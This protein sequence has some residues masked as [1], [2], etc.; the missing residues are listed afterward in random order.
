M[1]TRENA[2]QLRDSLAP[3]RFGLSNP[4]MAA[5]DSPLLQQYKAHYGLS[6][7][8]FDTP[9]HHVFGTIE[10]RS[11]QLVC[12]Y[13]SVPGTEQKGTA[14]LLHGYFDH[15]GIYG[16]L[17]R[18]CLQQGL[19]VVILDLP[20]HGLSSGTVGSI[21]SFAQYTKALVD[22]LCL[23]ESQLVNKPWSLIGQSTGGAVIID[24]LLSSDL[25][26][27]YTF[28]HVVVL[29]P[30]LR[31]RHW[32]RNKLLFLLT[33]RFT[34]STSR[35][36]SVNSHDKEFLQFLQHHDQLQSRYLSADWIDAMIHYQNRFRKAPQSNQLLHIIQ[37]SGDGTVDWQY[38]LPKLQQKF[39]AAKTYMIAGARHH[40]VNELPE[41]RNKV[42]SVLDEILKSNQSEM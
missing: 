25:I 15:A 11:F 28:E 9:V 27:T 12:Q 3:I 30:L 10:S 38:N 39:P 17:I 23:A 36:F 34:N 13:F 26:A 40:L 1:F 29:G 21:D 31:P 18:Q 32:R 14:F 42:F 8:A 4:T 33:R 35:K 20:G 2:S 7:S 5:D 22:C 19:A 41:Y 24:T 6:F 16:H 37:G